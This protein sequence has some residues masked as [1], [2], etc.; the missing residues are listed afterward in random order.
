VGVGAGPRLIAESAPEPEEGEEE[1]K[2]SAER[3]KGT[4]K[5][6]GGAF[7]SFGGEKCSLKE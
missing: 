2:L 1:E 3:S 4:R 5:F 7:S 6:C